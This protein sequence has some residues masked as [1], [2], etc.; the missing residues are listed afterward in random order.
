MRRSRIGT[1]V[2]GPDIRYA[3]S[4]E[5]SIAY[6]MLGDGPFE[7]ELQGDGDD[8]GGRAGAGAPRSDGHQSDPSRGCAQSSPGVRMIFQIM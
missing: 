4:D 8:S 6:S 5:A 3:R 1:S 7:L 2:V